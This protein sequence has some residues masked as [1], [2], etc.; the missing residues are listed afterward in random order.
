[1]DFKDIIVKKIHVPTSTILTLPIDVIENKSKLISILENDYIQYNPNTE[2]ILINGKNIDYNNYTG[3]DIKKS[4]LIIPRNDY[5]N[6]NSKYKVK[7]QYDEPYNTVSNQCSWISKEF[8]ENKNKLIES[9][10]ENNIQKLHEI[11]NLCMINGTKNRQNFGNLSE[12]E[13]IDQIGLTNIIESTIYGNPSILQMLP[14]DIVDKIVK[15]HIKSIYYNVFFEKMKNLSNEQFVL[16]NRDGQTFAFLK[17]NNQFYIFDSH[18]REIKI[19]NFQELTKYILENNE[20][21]FFYIL[22]SIS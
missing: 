11:Y 10:K 1:M 6:S 22:F 5:Y 2:A 13:N 20:D 3:N 4:I 8:I 21:G 16:I 15:P 17:I 12:G 7:S 18:I 19:C 9:I 14:K